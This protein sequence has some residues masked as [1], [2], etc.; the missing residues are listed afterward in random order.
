[1][2]LNNRNNNSIIF[3][4]NLFSADEEGKQ[5]I[6]ITH[7]DVADPEVKEGDVPPATPQEDVEGNEEEEMEGVDEED[8]EEV[9]HHI[10]VMH[11]T[12]PE[13]T[14]LITIAEPTGAEGECNGLV[15][16]LNI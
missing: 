2:G 6:L 4:H 13:E 16:N 14:Q 1:M 5:S 11:T 10:F 7:L 15:D 3:L 9:K 8:R 12:E